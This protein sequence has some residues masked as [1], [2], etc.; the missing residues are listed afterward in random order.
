ME[1]LAIQLV[2]MTI[3]GG[4]SAAIASSKG[5]TPVGW[6]FGGFFLGLIGL[7]I[8]ACLSN[9]NEEQSHRDHQSR[10][11]R[12]LREQLRQERMKGEAFRQHA[13]SRLDSHDQQ[14]GVDTRQTYQALPGFAEEHPLLEAHSELDQLSAAQED[15]EPA[16]PS[17]DP[18]AFNATSAPA[19]APRPR[20]NPSI[21]QAPRQWHYEEAG[22]PIGP[23]PESQLVSLARSGRITGATL[24]WTEELGDWKAA[25]Q[26]RALKPFIRA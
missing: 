22:Q 1:G 21:E 10:E 13:L 12:R 3:L 17:W 2:I 24:V 15:D 25:G 16:R 20:V 26:I 23:I 19:P 18:S 8:V 6:F 5:R 11:N 7:I 4:I 14:L 9:L